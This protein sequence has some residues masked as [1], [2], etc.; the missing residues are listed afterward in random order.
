MTMDLLCNCVQ[1]VCGFHHSLHTMAYFSKNVSNT[2]TSASPNR[3]TTLGTS[4]GG[5][6]G[7]GTV[8]LT[9]T[10]SSSWKPSISLGAPAL[11]EGGPR[12]LEDERSV[13]LRACG[14]PL[15]AGVLGFGTSEPNMPSIK[16]VI[17]AILCCD[18]E[19]EHSVKLAQKKRR[20]DTNSTRRAQHGPHSINVLDWDKRYLTGWASLVF[21]VTP[22]PQV[23]HKYLHA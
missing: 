16:E 13:L 6:R 2:P 20:D 8:P 12:G 22:H 5:P 3:S 23:V 9:P 11:S 7:R 19:L 17:F 21:M 15:E 18:K 10:T 1:S 4:P 14:S